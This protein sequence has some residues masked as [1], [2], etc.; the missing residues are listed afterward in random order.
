MEDYRKNK[1][2]EEINQY[3]NNTLD[4]AAEDNKLDYFNIEINNHNGSLQ[5]EFTNMARK[6]VY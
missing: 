3:I 2:K 5:L 6:K 1:L 4:K